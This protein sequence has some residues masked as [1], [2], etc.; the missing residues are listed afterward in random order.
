MAA[1]ILPEAAPVAVNNKCNLDPKSWKK[2]N[3]T[4]SPDSYLNCYFT[5]LSST[6][7]PDGGQSCRYI[8]KTLT[9]A[10]K[11]GTTGF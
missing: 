7:S 3:N 11:S 6:H 1:I 4:N 9:K 2:N 10:D 8:D 5:C